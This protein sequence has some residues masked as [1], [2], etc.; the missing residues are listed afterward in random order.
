[1]NAFF[2]LG[3]VI[4]GIAVALLAV[5]RPRVALLLLI[6]FDISNL[7][8]VIAEQ[9]GISPYKPQ[10]ALAILVLLIIL[11]QRRPRL[12]W[13]PVLLGIA[14]LFAGFCVTLISTDDPATSQALLSS[15]SRDLFYFVVVYGLL[16]A[17]GEIIRAAKGIVLVLAALAGL[18]VVHEFVLHNS[19]D[20][21]G[22]SRVPL[23]QEGGAFT[24]RH[25]GTSSDV[26][27]WARLL[28]L[29]SPLALS[30]WSIAS[31]RPQ[32][33]LWTSC[34]L[35]L[36]AG[37][38][39]TQSRG[40]FIALFVAV[41]GWMWFAGGRY[42]KSLL[43]APVAVAVLVPL[44]GIASRLGTLSAITA[45]SGAAS[46]D[47]SVITRKRLQ[48]DALQMFL[49]SP[50]TGHGIGSY[51]AIFHRYDRLSDHYQP[52]DIVVAAH[53]LYL[54]QAA[55]GGIVLLL[56]W[57]VFV[58]S[59]L[60][61]AIRARTLAARA[62]DL[63]TNRLALGVVAG[64]VGWLLASVFLHLS[65]FRALLV[66]AALAA[67]LDV[68]ARRLTVPPV[69][70]AMK[71]VRAPSRPFQL[72]MAA[73]AVLSLA[74]LVLSLTTGRVEY[75]NEATLAV[76]PAATGPSG[77]A[78]YQ[79]DVVSRGVIVPTLA[80]ILDS[81][82]STLELARVSGTSAAD[83]SAIVEPSTLGGAV[84]LTVTAPNRASA[85]VLGTAAVALAK[86]RVDD[87]DTSYQLT[88]EMAGARVVAPVRRWL[89]LP[90]L[91]SLSG[92]GLILLRT[93]R[94]RLG[95]AIQPRKE[96]LVSVP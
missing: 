80:T 69:L 40:G 16:L 17:T 67:A 13:S 64:L 58:G 84:L 44:T 83:A 7:N 52:V 70:P 11:V 37:V 38:Y 39:L 63:A 4:I 66:V 87:L 78:A 15:R 49:D 74:G 86:S 42:R 94:R 79:L 9:I 45:S 14:I 82:L 59:V 1:M 81:S 29:V 24:P 21:Y 36:L 10:L 76:V 90:L 53:N 30:L 88:G 26:N 60:F 96:D 23:V 35:A 72:T 2:L 85:D 46:A 50:I 27:F 28:I 3:A 61:C 22:L 12:A 93:S 47:V 34:A 5:V 32:R 92:A 43:L 55:D 73:L 6:T 91:L 68:H 65:D 8:G 71:V 62:G 41:I 56:A 33:L 57:S 89:A 25:A 48:L 51:V 77:S 31:R 19:G 75:R 18:T 20:L 54:E 95:A